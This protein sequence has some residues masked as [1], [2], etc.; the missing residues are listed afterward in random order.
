MS[1]A[2][3]PDIRIGS[4]EHAARAARGTAVVIDVF[5][6]FTTAAVAFARGAECIVFAASLEEALAWRENG[7]GRICLGERGG[8]RPDGFD[9]GN[10]PLEL[11]DADLGGA[12]LIQTTSNGTRGVLAALTGAERVY[13]TAFANAEAT[14]RA[15]AA[16]GSGPVHLI[17]M[18]ADDRTRQEED[19]LCA[20]YLRARLMGRRPDFEAIRTA[21]LTLGTGRDTTILT[22]EDIDACLRLDRFDRAIQV[23]LENGRA[24]ARPV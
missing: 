15:A 12:T 5:R 1:D 23:T 20:Y 18:G 8:V 2:A 17:A 3:A 11:A 21:I 16:A 10:S 19:E 6:A 13:A 22:Q 14:V 7:V 4:F 9:F 24:T